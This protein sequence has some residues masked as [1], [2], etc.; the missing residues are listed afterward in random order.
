MLEND[1]SI[2]RQVSERDVVR[3]TQPETNPK[4]SNCYWVQQTNV[5]D[6]VIMATS[7]QWVSGIIYTISSISIIMGH[8]V[9]LLFLITTISILYIHNL[10]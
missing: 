10:R 1:I 7:G 6:T 9:I 4:K 8:V 5:R 3:L 2:R